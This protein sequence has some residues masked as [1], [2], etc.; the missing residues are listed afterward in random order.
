MK[1]RRFLPEW[2]AAKE[3]IELVLRPTREWFNALMPD[4]N[5]NVTVRFSFMD[6]GE[7][8][9]GDAYTVMHAD[10]M[11]LR[12]E[13]TRDTERSFPVFLGTLSRVDN[14]WRFGIVQAAVCGGPRSVSRLRGLLRHHDDWR[15]VVTV[16]GQDPTEVPSMEELR[17]L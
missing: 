1:R 13:G 3:E 16:L 10:I 14:V 11:R 9:F 7:L 5:G 12:G 4:E 6:D 17:E 8:Y 15:E 2:R